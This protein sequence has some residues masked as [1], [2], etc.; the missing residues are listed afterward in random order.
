MKLIASLLA[1]FS[2]L[3]LAS[4]FHSLVVTVDDAKRD[5][6]TITGKAPRGK[7]TLQCTLGARTVVLDTALTTIVP[8]KSTTLQAG[9]SR[10]VS[11]PPL[12]HT[13][14]CQGLSLS[15]LSFRD[16]LVRR[17]EYRL[18]AVADIAH[19]FV[20]PASAGLFAFEVRRGSI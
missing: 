15:V 10:W 13:T 9:G 11:S 7:W 16:S 2:L 4:A 12:A 17:K 3:Q 6:V 20:G 5:K 14:W 19:R 18:P 1:L 8:S